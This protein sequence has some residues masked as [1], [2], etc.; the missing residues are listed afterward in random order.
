M[1]KIKLTGAVLAVGA[2]SMFALAPAFADDTASSAPMVHCKGGNSCKGQSSCK[3]ADNSCKGQ[4]SCKGKGV[5]KMTK[6]EC[7]KA[8]GT[9][10]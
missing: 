5:V 6:E 7:E 2:A 8:G 4:N 10:Q 3:T 1:N 9:A